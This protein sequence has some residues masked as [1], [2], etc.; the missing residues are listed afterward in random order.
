MQF[1][2]KSI[3]VTGAATGI[4]KAT[5]I[6][7]AKAGASVTIGDVLDAAQARGL[8]AAAVSACGGFCRR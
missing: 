2:N 8:V 3:I 4:G 7:F 6:A 5:A 1:E